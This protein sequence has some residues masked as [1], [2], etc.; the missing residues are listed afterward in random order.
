MFNINL[1]YKETEIGNAP[2]STELR[3]CQ[4]SESTMNQNSFIKLPKYCGVL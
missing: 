3:K 1:N 2:F 4:Y